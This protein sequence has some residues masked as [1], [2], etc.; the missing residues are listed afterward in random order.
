MDEPTPTPPGR[1]ILHL[2]CP[3]FNDSELQTDYLTAL[4]D[5]LVR[6]LPAGDFLTPVLI[7]SKTRIKKS[8]SE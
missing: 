5:F 7:F 8:A 6:M 1:G 3:L 2:S 4:S